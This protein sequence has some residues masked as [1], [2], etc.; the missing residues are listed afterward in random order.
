M[1]AASHSAIVARSRSSGL[2]LKDLQRMGIDIAP[3]AGVSITEI[4][5]LV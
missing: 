5:E 1:G 4:T 2:A 3:M